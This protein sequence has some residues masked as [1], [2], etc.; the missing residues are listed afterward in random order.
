MRMASWSWGGRPHAGLISPCGREAA[1]LAVTD[2]GRGTLELI[3]RLAFGEPLPAPAG[4]GMGF[5]P[6]RWLLGSD[7]VRVEVDGIG[8]IDN[9]SRS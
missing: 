9:E 3:R 7:R 5:S 2:P 4:V 8:A 6:P 1:P